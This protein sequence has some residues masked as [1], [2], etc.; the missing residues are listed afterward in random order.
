MDTEA[1]ARSRRLLP[2][3]HE[4]TA[5]T[6]VLIVD[7]HPLVRSALIQQVYSL[8]PAATVLTAGTVE[9]ARRTAS[10]ASS[11]DLV[12]LDLNLP[13][14]NGLSLLCHWGRTMPDVPVIV[15]SG[16][17]E[18]RRIGEA[19]A[20]G[21]RAFVAKNASEASLR[22]AIAEVLQLPVA[23][24]AAR[25]AT[26]FDALTARQQQVLRALVAG[27]SNLDIAN[28]L[29]ISEPTVKVHLTAIFRR[30]GV[31]SRTQAVL[32]ARAAGW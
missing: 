18:D 11:I 7:D 24:E 5:V 14:E 10:L 13:D 2:Q 12:I 21:A 22:L 25:A 27:K 17:S 9:L 6:T 1:C 16:E 29:S 31:V 3:P 23:P 15:V 28:Q 4:E 30:L 32:A 20:A 19:R 26:A 8:L